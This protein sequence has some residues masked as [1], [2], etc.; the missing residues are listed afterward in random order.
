MAEERVATAL[1][2]LTAS[3]AARLIR[4]REISPVELVQT[5][6]ARIAEVDERVHAWVTVDPEG[7]LAAARVAEQAVG[8]ATDRQSLHGVP[9]GAKDIFDS[10]GLVTMAGFHPYADRIPTSDS[11]PIT[12]LKRAGAILLGKLVTTQF[13]QADPSPAR[14][15]WAD[16]R[17]PGGSSS[18]SAVS[19][20]VRAVPFALG[21]QTAGSV[22]RP[23]AYNGVVG[24]KP[25]SGLISKQG[26]LPLAWSLDHVGLLARSV[27][28]CG[29]F[30]AA[31]SGHDPG[32]LEM[33]NAPRLGLPREALDHATPRLRDHVLETA[34]QFEAAGARVEEVSLG[35]PMDLILAVHHVIMQTEAA[36][37]HWQLLE[38]Y[39]GAHMPR[40]R[41]YVEVGRLLP[42]VAYMHAQRLRQRIRASMEAALEGFDALLL[43][44]ATDVA[45]GRE[46]TGDPSLQAPF[47]LVGFPSLSLPSGL[48][49]PDDLPLAIQL[50]SPRGR[51]SQLL[52]V[53]RWCEARL[54]PM[55]APPL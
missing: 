37:V 5:L 35:E 2:E 32:D 10:A 31:A 4:T 44:T 40:L 34:K 6:L 18:G 26:V 15:P 25:T 33:E 22:L 17:T 21:S 1:H 51:D 30:L 7:A 39:P 49:Q 55:P 36:G 45:P 46:T 14:N 13:A 48:S 20:A 8:S 41:A 23:A 3:Q 16:D 11:E 50:A 42:G 12:R 53:G 52:S 28:D 9:F 38:Q 24:F 54:A 29:L 27:E 19:V 43:P 47:S